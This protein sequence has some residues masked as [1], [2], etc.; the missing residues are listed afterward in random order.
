MAND[1]YN[2][3]NKPVANPNK[4]GFDLGSFFPY[5]LKLG[6]VKPI[7][8]LQAVPKGHYKI[9]IDELCHTEPFVT[10]PF[11]RLTKHIEVVFTPLSQLWHGSSQFFGHAQDP[12]SSY[13]QGHAYVPN[14]DLGA[15]LYRIWNAGITGT[16][17]YQYTCD[18]QQLCIQE[19]ALSLLDM[20]G[21]GAHPLYKMTDNERT[22]YIDAHRGQYVNAFPLLAYNKYWNTY[23][24]DTQHTSPLNPKIFNADCVPCTSV[25][26]SHMDAYYTDA[27]MLELVTIKYR[28]VKKDIFTSAL[29]S[30][31][32]GA[33][34]G[35]AMNFDIVGDGGQI[36]NLV[37]D[38]VR[39]NYDQVRFVQ[40]SSVESSILDAEVQVSGNDV[41]PLG[42]SQ[43]H[44]VYAQSN[45]GKL[46]DKKVNSI[47]GTID[48][49]SGSASF[50]VYTLLT[51][52]LMQKWREQIQRAGNRTED[53]LRALYGVA[54]NS[55]AKNSPFIVGST[56]YPIVANQVTSTGSSDG[57]KLADI[58]AKGA[59][60]SQRNEFEFTASEFGILTVYTYILPEN[61]YLAPIDK[62][63]TMIEPFDFFVEQIENLGLEQVDGLYRGTVQ[64]DPDSGK[65]VRKTFESPGFAARYWCYKQKLNVVHLGFEHGQENSKW[66]PSRVEQDVQGGLPRDLNP[67]Y[68]APNEYDTVFDTSTDY[69]IDTDQF[70]CGCKVSCNSVLPMS[71]LG[72]PR[73]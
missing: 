45:I 71:E 42:S 19:S 3:L 54:P 22:A 46:Y 26:T 72:L 53:R 48:G 67:Y 50:D 55:D 60:Y 21:Y 14:F 57:A 43:Q 63:N 39:G 28:K 31:Q 58:A 13:E 40:P 5:S 32:F 65:Y 68:V 62:T 44:V 29:T 15:M 10:D 24:R 69:H 7:Y 9:N 36:G 61:N 1:I 64:Y 23:L 49:L 51:A 33:V 11:V 25:A 56:S 47:N 17:T 37:T 70:I 16:E 66:M 38:V 30:R 6:Q 52:Q 41:Y 20:L 2:I 73:W 4:N 12:Q 27:E 18:M 59:G 8:F 34:E 35:V